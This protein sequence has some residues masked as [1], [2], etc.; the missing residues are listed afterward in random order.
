[1]AGTRKFSLQYIDRHDL[2]SLTREASD[3]TGIP[4][5]ME[6]DLEEADRILF[7]S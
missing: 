6:S 7:D 1:M 2:V 3:V 5:I 4:Y